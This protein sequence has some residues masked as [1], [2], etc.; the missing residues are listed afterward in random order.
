MRDIERFTLLEEFSRTGSPE[1]REKLIVEYAPLVKIVAGRLSMY[2][3]DSCEFD[4]LVGYGVIGLIEALDNFDPSKDV[5]FETY[6]S[7]K[8]RGYILDSIREDGAIQMHN[9]SWE[10]LIKNEDF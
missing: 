2:L 4:D 10:D 8:I 1:I 7:L 6:A 9:I 5:K 3:G